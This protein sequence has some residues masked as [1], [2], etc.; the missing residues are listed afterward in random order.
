MGE[1]IGYQAGGAA[2]QGY[3]ARPD[4]Q[5]KGGVVVIQ[6]W[7]GL[8]PHIKDVADRFAQAGYLALA[9]DLWDGQATRQ[10]DE[11][12]RL[13]MALDVASAAAKI[14]GAARALRD[15]GATGVGVVGFCMGGQLALYAACASPELYQACVDYYGVHPRVHPDFSRL[16][17][18]VLGHFGKDDASVPP[19]RAHQMNRELAA[20]AS[21]AGGH[22]EVH[23]YDAGHAFANDARPEAYRPEAAALAW[24]RTLDFL[25]SNL[26]K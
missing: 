19:E 11:A 7:W 13:F 8:V 18:P 10:P 6:E 9:P 15:Q 2:A 12:Q 5:A 17:C 24:R 23:V 26:A 25:A 14:D 3:L 22:M 20:R 16:A 1:M 4:G 21:K